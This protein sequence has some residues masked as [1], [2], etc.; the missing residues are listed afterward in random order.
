MPPVRLLSR[1]FAPVALPAESVPVAAV[2]LSVPEGR[3]STPWLT[4][5]GA[6]LF[7]LTLALAWVGAAAA[8]WIGAAAASWVGAAAATWTGAAAAT[9]VRGAAAPMQTP[10]Q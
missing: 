8:T 3:C 1:S 6:F 10:K 4:W 7:A 9:L 5:L 2:A